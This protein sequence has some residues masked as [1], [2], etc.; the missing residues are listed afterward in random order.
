MTFVWSY[1]NYK[2]VKYLI[3]I[4]VLL[5]AYPQT[6]T[7]QWYNKQFVIGTFSDPRISR[8]NDKVKDS[9]SFQY[10]KS[11]YFNLLSGPQFYNGAR[12]YSLMDKTLT[13]ASRF[14]MHVLLIDSKL[15]VADSSFRKEDAMNIISYFKSVDKSKRDAIGGYYFSGEFPKKKAGQIK[16]W[17]GFFKNNDPDKMAY[18]YLLPSYAFKSRSEYED[19]LD[20]YLSGNGTDKP[21]VIAYDHYPFVG[22]NATLSS[23]FYNLNIIKQKAGSTPFWY[24]I[25]TTTKKTD[26]ADVNDYQLKFMAYCPLAYGAKGVI[27][28]TYETIP[29]NHGWNYRDAII[30]RD[31]RPTTKYNT[32]K[33]INEYLKEV[34]GPVILRSKNIATLHVSEQ[35]TGEDLPSASLLRSNK[36]IVT[37]VNSPQLLLGIFKDNNGAKSYLMV[38][39]KASSDANSVIVTL[40]GK[41]N[42][43]QYPQSDNYNGQLSVTP[44]TENYNARRNTTS[45][46]IQ[47]LG[48]GEMALF[49]IN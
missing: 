23:Y 12:D 33:K 5:A 4:F 9:I 30:G 2:T 40:A 42:V 1:P 39:N 16:Y 19:Y 47:N 43:S 46:S 6:G 49:E 11:A 22:G 17:T 36:S 35:P 31:G 27:Y 14:G 41:K 29:D 3:G 8:D 21:E 32:A 38:I 20:N 25:L 10:A 26:P 48:G 18:S 44:I 13:L 45:F 7:A 34:A 24:Y 15:R 37:D 28:Y